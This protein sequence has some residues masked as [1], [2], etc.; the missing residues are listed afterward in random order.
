[1]SESSMTRLPPF[2]RVPAEIRLIIYELL[3]SDH[4]DKILRI[5]TEDPA[6]YQS[7][8]GEER[9]RRSFRYIQD[10]M[11]SRSGESTYGLIKSPGL[12]PSILG[13]SRQIHAEA[14]HVLY[15]HTF[16]FGLDVESILPFLQDLTPNALSSIKRIQ[17]TKRSLPYTKDFDRCEWR[18]ACDYISKNLSLLQL[19]LV[20]YGGTPSLANRPALH[21]KQNSTY[22]KVDFAL[23]S[24]LKECEDD[25]GW[26]KQVAA[27]KGLQV[28]NV[29]AVLE[30]CPIPSSKAMAFFVNFSASIEE[31][32]TD[33][34][35]SHMV[36]QIS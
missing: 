17:L 8:K 24:K 27:I 13:V 26:V 14:S 31:G 3:L 25:M 9:Q 16:D 20:V 29:K 22:T 7:R 2:L 28:L 23:I 34:L 15:S 1:M 33:Y 18:N 30:H 36:T 19:D 35:K 12:H 5:R 11:R 6:T 4:D 21:W 32:F 10:R